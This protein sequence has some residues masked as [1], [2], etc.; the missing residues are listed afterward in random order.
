[1][2]IIL[3]KGMYKRHTWDNNNSRFLAQTYV[4]SVYA[5]LWRLNTYIKLSEYIVNWCIVSKYSKWISNSYLLN[6][7]LSQLF[8][9]DTIFLLVNTLFC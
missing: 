1:M 2:S 9:A 6:P 4:Q 8:I 5:N 7:L 3:A